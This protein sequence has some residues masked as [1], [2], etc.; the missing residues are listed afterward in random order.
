LGTF[1]SW[2]SCRNK[3]CCYVRSFSCFIRSQWCL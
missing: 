2:I 1:I 3:Y